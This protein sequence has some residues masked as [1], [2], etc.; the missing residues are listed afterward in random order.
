[1]AIAQTGCV[2]VIGDKGFVIAQTPPLM[3]LHIGVFP[4]AADQFGKSP[5]L[6]F[7]HKV[8]K[9]VGPELIDGDML[10]LQ[11]AANGLEG[12]VKNGLNVGGLANPGHHLGHQPF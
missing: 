4:T 3:L 5:T 7:G 12:G 2:N 11:G 10:N 1:M 8:A 6:G 9:K